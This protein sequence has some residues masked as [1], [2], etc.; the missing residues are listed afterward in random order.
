MR[1]FSATHL[2]GLICLE[3]HTALK[4]VGGYAGRPAMPN[5]TLCRSSPS[6]AIS[7]CF[8]Q[9][10]RYAV[11]AF[12]K[13]KIWKKDGISPDHFHLHKSLL[14]TRPK[15]SRFTWKPLTSWEKSL[16]KSRFIFSAYSLDFTVPR[17]LLLSTHHLWN[18]MA[19]LAENQKLSNHFF[20]IKF[21]AHWC[22]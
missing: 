22:P 8:W 14:Y 13:I 3:R 17:K 5:R 11:S 18:L 12:L 15:I 7:I 1:I 21:F 9:A 6:N 19:M 16:T 4:T 2:E 10:Y 20:H